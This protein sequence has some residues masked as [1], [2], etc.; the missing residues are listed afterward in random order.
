M[1]VGS[2][3]APN[4]ER[5][6]YNLSTSL[7]DNFNIIVF[8]VRKKYPSLNKVQQLVCKVKTQSSFFGYLAYAKSFYAAIKKNEVDLLLQLNSPMTRG[9]I[10]AMVSRLTGIPYVL[11]IPGDKLSIYQHTSGI[12]K[13]RNYFEN[14]IIGVALFK[15]TKHIVVV[16]EYLKSRIAP[17]LSSGQNIYN[18]YQPLDI[19][20]FKRAF[21]KSHYR[22]A[23]GIPDNKRII[24]YIGRLS[25]EK[26]ADIL[27][28]IICMTNQASND[29]LFLVIGEGKHKPSISKLENTQ[30]V[31]MV[32][33]LE[34]SNYYLA[35]DILVFP[36]RREGVP[37]VILESLI[38]KLPIACSEAGEMPFLVSKPCKTVTDYVEKLTNTEY[39]AEPTS[40]IEP[41]LKQKTIR[42]QY[43]DLFNTAIDLQ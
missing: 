15:R 34:I 26:G 20:A 9:P 1:L 41:L 33:F 6:I 22:K 38:C 24:L 27:E 43:I 17:L 23:L 35:A 8:G 7:A 10:V 19:T 14:N 29:H 3:L 30:C 31:G 25:L 2:E 42:Q 11:R 12:T 37:N 36:S 5:L 13:A 32:P 28:E 4:E 21:S 40:T 16:G 18:I 39:V